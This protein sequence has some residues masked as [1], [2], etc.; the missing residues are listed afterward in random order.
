MSLNCTKY[1]YFLAFLDICLQIWTMIIG[2]VASCVRGVVTGHSR[3]NKLS[4]FLLSRRV[5]WD[6]CFFYFI[7]LRERLD[8]IDIDRE[9]ALLLGSLSLSLSLSRL[10]S[11]HPHFLSSL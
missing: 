11:F 7:N 2:W 9:V 6:R 4:A 8:L 10:F 1:S 5:T 3:L